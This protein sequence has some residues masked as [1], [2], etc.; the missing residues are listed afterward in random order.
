MLL[1]RSTLC[2]SSVIGLLLS[3]VILAAQASPGAAT[4]AATPPAAET[5]ATTTLS[6][7]AN[8]VNLPVVV[9]DKKGALVQNLAKADFSLSVDG[10]PQVI[11]YF[12]HDQNLPLTL[13]LL[14]DTSQSQRSVLDEERDASSSFLDG[15]LK[16]PPNQA[17]DRAFLIQF[18][19]EVEL[20]Q[21]LTS[22]RPKLQAAVK[23]IG[24][25]NP[26]ERTQDPDVDADHAPSGDPD[27]GAN[28]GGPTTTSH[29]FRRG[30]RELYDA[31]YL[32]AND[33][34]LKQQGRKAIVILSDGVDR[35]SKKTLNQALEAA[36]RADMMIFTIYFKGQDQ[37]K[38]DLGNNGPGGNG[39][40]RYPGGGG[41]PGG[42]YPGGGYP[43]GGRRGGAQEPL[44]DRVDGKRILQQM[45]NET[46]G[47]F[48]EAR[49][50]GNIAELYS[51]IAEELRSQYRLGYTPDATISSDGY[52]R[53]ELTIPGQK[54][55]H[56][57][58][59]D[60]YYT[61]K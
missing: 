4:N 11:R 43:G 49:N 44:E 26:N 7:N 3:P 39:F 47:R 28:N 57:Q 51:Q 55:D 25:A 14:V 36:Q 31:L 53:V 22:S 33:L 37:R 61:G 32:S 34:M 27:S 16:A 15:L 35:N 2:A 48:F 52:H 41:Y 45:S 6:L 21:D 54:N 17:P 13:G 29:S 30:R 9:R 50:K 19:S 1:Q 46:G 59:R 5:Q 10:H 38:P 40:P 20:L 42:G 12:G 56:V 58:T 18:S 24:T 60:G 23:E 8:L